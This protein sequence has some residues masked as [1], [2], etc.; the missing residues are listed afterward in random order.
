MSTM[1]LDHSNRNADPITDEPG[2]HPV[3]TGI[4]GA[5]G[6]AIAGA[7]IGTVVG[8]V[9]TA[10]GAAIGAI[11]GGFAGKAVA[12]T[13]N[14]TDAATANEEHVASEVKESAETEASVDGEPLVVGSSIYN[15]AS[16]DTAVLIVDHAAIAALA[17]SLW[18]NRGCG[19]GHALEDWLE[20]EK[21][22][23]AA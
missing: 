16:I 4:G 14:P 2:S 20:A 5:V 7:M 21:M 6:G 18:Q 9:G 15:M 8:P 1:T 11:A 10:I 19:D 22:L 17:Y 23:L 12:E 13:V 3:G